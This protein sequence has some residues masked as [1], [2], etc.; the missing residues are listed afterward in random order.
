MLDFSPIDVA[1]LIFLTI[2]SSD[3]L[4]KKP[5][6]YKLA[7]DKSLILITETTCELTPLTSPQ[8]T[9][10]NGLVHEEYP[11]SSLLL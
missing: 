3:K 4:P 6:E 10:L 8:T 7:F 11:F 1:N 2:A 5:N 9:P